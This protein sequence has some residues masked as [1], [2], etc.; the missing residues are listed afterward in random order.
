ML[1]NSFFGA[2]MNKDGS[3]LA[4]YTRSGP[5]YRLGPGNIWTS[6]DYGHTWTEVTNTTADWMSITSSDD[7]QYVAAVAEEGGIWTSTDFGASWSSNNNHSSSST[8]NFNKEPTKNK[9]KDICSSG[10][11]SKL[12]AVGRNMLFWISSDY[13]ATW[14]E[15]MDTANGG[16]LSTDINALYTQCAVSSDGLKMAVLWYQYQLWLSSDGGV[17]WECSTQNQDGSTVSASATVNISPQKI[18]VGDYAYGHSTAITV[19]IG[20]EIG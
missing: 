5:S 12:L 4:G 9:Y 11:G 18:Q 19:P 1:R 14:T 13:G 20:Q 17:S 10:D 6:S 7:G 3:K 2:T 15:V 16:T 8:N